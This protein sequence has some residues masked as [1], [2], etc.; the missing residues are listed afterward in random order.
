M[1]RSA[2]LALLVALLIV[3][4]AFLRPAVTV[5]Q[6][7]PGAR[8]FESLKTKYLADLKRPSL[9]IRTR[10]TRRLCET[11]D[12][13]A[14]D[15]MLARYQKPEDPDDHVQYLTA[16]ITTKNF[17]TS[18]YVDKLDQWADKNK[19]DWDG[20]LWYRTQGVHVK[21][22]GTAEVI[23]NAI[24]NRNE[25]F[26]VS[27]IEA[28]CDAKSPE[29]LTLIPKIM[30]D[31]PRR[32]IGRSLLVEA[33]AAGLYA[34][35]EQATTPAF[36]NAALPV[37]S[38]LGDKDTEDR[39]KLVIAR[40]LKATL[41][42]DRAGL[43]PEYWLSALDGKAAQAA[44]GDG[45]ANQPTFIGI[46]GAGTR[47]AYVID[48]SD[49]MLT[50]LSVKEKDEL[51]R[52]ITG[53]P[54]PTKPDDPVKNDPPIN[55]PWDSIKNRFDAAR[56][57]LKLSLNGLPDDIEFTIITFGTKAT[58]MEGLTGLVKASKSNVRRVIASLDAIRPG[59]TATNRPH[60]TLQGMTNLHGGIMRAFQVAGNGIVSRYEQVDKKCFEKGVDTI[61][62]L[63]DGAP[64]YDDFDATDMRDPEDQGGDPE[65]GTLSQNT[66]QLIYY[67][68]YV[69]DT[70]HLLDDIRRMNIYRKVQIHC[71]GI[72]EADASLLEAIT[73][74][75]LGKLRRIGAGD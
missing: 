40:H 55:L 72:G 9:F 15:M 41:N 47:I 32:G 28:M 45:Y 20:W 69:V 35:K 59:P 60:G 7:A 8:D 74:R 67:G 4:G 68:P 39:S 34:M 46:E 5:A 25:F 17:N 43:N 61:F 6:P 12:P 70:E 21:V 30:A 50:P 53:G 65:A 36:R 3:L 11:K 52:V 33:C 38:A 63:S 31:L 1:P 23:T 26:R 75:G 71:V 49:S 42:T 73:E 14:F 54:N 62:V 24:E 51:K 58:L 27:S 66:P 44:M 37:I 13:R 16:A 22:K 19:K 57:F 29:L 18:Q 56:E 2:T 48:L 64:S 10:S